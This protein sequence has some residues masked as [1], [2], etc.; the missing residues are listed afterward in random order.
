M[1]DP[2][3]IMK[4][5]KKCFVQYQRKKSAK[6]VTNNTKLNW[7]FVWSSSGLVLVN[8]G[9]EREKLCGLLCWRH[10]LSV[11]NSQQV[12]AT[13]DSLSLSFHFIHRRDNFNSNEF[14]HRR[15]NFCRVQD[16][17]IC[18]MIWSGW[19][20]HRYIYGARRL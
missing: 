16:F 2:L 13:C 14:E 12:S 15:Y 4:Y 1:P 17:V 8:W 3:H 20:D 7:E 19:C 6:W 18:C 9:K 5:E 10:V 11:L